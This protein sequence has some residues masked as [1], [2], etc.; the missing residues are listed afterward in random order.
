MADREVMKNVFQIRKD[1]Q[2]MRK[3]DHIDE[4]LTKF[5]EI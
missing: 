1:S 5:A 4:S 3:V 2:I